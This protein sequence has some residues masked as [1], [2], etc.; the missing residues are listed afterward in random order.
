M[1]F[2]VQNAGSSTIYIADISAFSPVPEPSSLA[3]IGLGA[4]ALL[5]RRRAAR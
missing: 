2:A 5:A 1:R 4:I 3:A